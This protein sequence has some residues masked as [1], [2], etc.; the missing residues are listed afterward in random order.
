[1]G[2]GM[3]KSTNDIHLIGL[4]KD[5]QERGSVNVAIS[6]K[7][8]QTATLLTQTDWKDDTFK[9]N[10]E[11]FEQIPLKSENKL[12]DRFPER[13]VGPEKIESKEPK[14]END[15]YSVTITPSLYFPQK[16]DEIVISLENILNE[17]WNVITVFDCKGASYLSI[18]QKIN[19][20]RKNNICN[21]L[22]I[23][24]KKSEYKWFAFHKFV[25][26]EKF[27]FLW[28]KDIW[29]S[30]P[31]KQSNSA[32]LFEN[33]NLHEKDLPILTCSI[34]NLDYPV[35]IRC[36][37]HAEKRIYKQITLNEAI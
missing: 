21:T 3:V 8:S 12:K 27:E 20:F 13:C 16:F 25:E 18:N 30:Y 24:I 35:L 15:L 7:Y 11:E 19:A 5:I 14:H 36:Y 10:N 32:T 37:K 26:K 2:S 33:S 23:F 4:V 1:M 22:G 17:T 6:R 9:T 34:P 28:A 31:S 29:F